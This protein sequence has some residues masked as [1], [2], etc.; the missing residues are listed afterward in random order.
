MSN[1][2]TGA[3]QGT[4]LAPFLFALD[5]ADCRSTDESKKLQMI[6]NWLEKIMIKMQY[7]TSRLK[8]VTN[9][10]YSDNILTTVK[11]TAVHYEAN[12]CAVLCETT[13]CPL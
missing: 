12:S 8:T 6:Q 4:V 9:M 5:A 10:F 3:P 2:N 13:S 7:T 11:L 1:Q